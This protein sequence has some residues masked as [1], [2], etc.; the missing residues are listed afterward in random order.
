[1]K[2]IVLFCLT[3]GIHCFSQELLFNESNNFFEFSKI[4]STQDS[5]ILNK[6]E[7]R[8]KEIN[9]TGIETEQNSIYGYGFTNHL[10]GGFATVEI[11]YKVKIDFKENKYKITI[12]NFILTDLNGSNPLEG[13]RSYKNKWIRII[14]KK[15]PSILSNIENIHSDTDKW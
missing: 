11:K 3:F 4:V 10:I 12:T 8:F 2:Y 13:M 6:F 14:N 1:M 5:L 15:L 9:L 7:K